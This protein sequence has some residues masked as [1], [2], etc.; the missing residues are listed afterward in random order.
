MLPRLRKSFYDFAFSP[1]DLLAAL[2]VAAYLV[3]S[4]IYSN[5]QLSVLDEG[6][7]LLKGFWF[8]TGQYIPYQDFGPFTN[9][10][11]LS[12]LIPGTIQ[13]WFGPGLATARIFAVIVG[14]LFLLGLWLITRRWG[15]PTWAA[16]AVWV[17]ALNP[18][19]IKMY[20]VGVSQ[21]IIIAML[22]WALYLVLGQDRPPWQIYLGVA[23]SALMALTRLN[24]TPVLFLLLLY[25]YWEN[26]RKIAIR[27]AMIG[28]GIWILGHALYWPGILQ[29]WANY[30][31]QSIT[32]FLDPWRIPAEAIPSW[33]S[34]ADLRG[35][36]LSLLETLR[37]HFVLLIA[38]ATAWLFW[39]KRAN[40]RSTS[41]FRAATFVS[42]LLLLLLG[43]HAFASLGADYCVYCLPLYTAFYS[44]LGILLLVIVWPNMQLAKN[45]T[46]HRLST[47]GGFLALIAVALGAYYSFSISQPPQRWV[48]L[49][50]NFDVP[51]I[52]GF[53]FQGG[54]L[55]FWGLLENRF[56]FSYADSFK[57]V[58]STLALAMIVLAVSAISYFIVWFSKRENKIWKP[59][60]DSPAIRSLFLLLI[61][62]AFLSPTSLLAGGYQ[63]YDCEQNVVQAY[64][65]LAIEL[66]QFIEAGDLVFWRGGRSAVPLLYFDDISTFPTQLNGDY[67]FR[68][69]GEAEQLTRAGLWGQ[70]VL[71]DWLR[72]ADVILIEADLYRTWLQE[73]IDLAL[74]NMW[75]RP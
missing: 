59:G 42:A 54:T 4:W 61:L 15:N 7:Y 41:E 50:L 51:R 10:M 40:W 73:A 46:K 52:Q 8:A 22:I 9:H 29:M 26:G 18:A 64:D 19:L 57:F 2:G 24:M 56:A 27:A 43:M 30:T 28:L 55:P 6:A 17:I 74:T 23:L 34:G 65:D 37:F 33:T 21:G 1:P 36:I 25:I 66:S 70:A 14:L 3:Q 48:R 44:V 5:T 71:E 75:A 31:P 45:K 72:Q 35:R 20:S 68:L 67:T 32:P 69:G 39:P 58:Q 53:S 62:G 11:P 16:V 38:A 47:L 63:T 60:L 12:F 49:I 13:A